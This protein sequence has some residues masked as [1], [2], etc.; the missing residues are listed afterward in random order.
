MDL[1]N[2]LVQIADQINNY[3]WLVLLVM[4]IINCIGLVLI[5]HAG[6]VNKIFYALLLFSDGIGLLTIIF[7]VAIACI[8]ISP[9]THRETISNGWII[10]LLVT[11]LSHVILTYGIFMVRE[12][13]LYIIYRIVYCFIFGIL[14]VCAIV[15]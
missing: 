1:K 6:V 3:S 12:Y 14:F 10:Y 9:E 5:I 2:Y 13:V 4:N 11:S 7:I 15:A 8:A